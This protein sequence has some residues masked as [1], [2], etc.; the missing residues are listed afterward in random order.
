[1]LVIFRILSYPI[2]VAKALSPVISYPISQL[3]PK[4]SLTNCVFFSSLTCR[5]LSNNDFQGVIFDID[6]IRQEIPGVNTD[7]CINII[8]CNIPRE[9]YSYT[10][11]G[12]ID[13]NSM[14]MP[15]W[16]SFS[17]W[18]MMNFKES[19]SRQ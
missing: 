14:T 15:Q 18:E 17:T 8:F 1:M 9:A 12:D 6:K 4:M 2:R 7:R 16:Y 19:E 5:G 11:A 10:T 3:K 13:G